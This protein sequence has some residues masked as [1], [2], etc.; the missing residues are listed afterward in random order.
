MPPSLPA[1]ST[2][3]F[4]SES[5]RDMVNALPNGEAVQ[6]LFAMLAAASIKCPATRITAITAGK[7]ESHFD[8]SIRRAAKCGKTK[9]LRVMF[10][11]QIVDP[12][13]DRQMWIQFVFHRN[14]DEAV[15]FDVEIRAAEI[16]FFARVY[17]L[18]FCCGAQSFAPKVRR[19]DVD[20]VARPPRQAR[21][22][23]LRNVRRR[24]LFRV[25]VGVAGREKQI[26]DRLRP[27]FRL[28]SLRFGCAQVERV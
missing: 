16:Q 6:L 19:R 5:S 4:L 26:G 18:C 28:Q 24:G 1:P 10:V 12:A 15:I 3:N 8:S 27:Q 17:K 20:F 13:E 21:A 14:V 25:E 9:N 2:A 23:Q 22:L 7:S 11:G